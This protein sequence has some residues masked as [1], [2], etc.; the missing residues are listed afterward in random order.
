MSGYLD[1]ERT[2][3]AEVDAILEMIEAAGSGYHNTS[4]WRDKDNGPSYLERINE[5]IRE[6][7]VVLSEQSSVKVT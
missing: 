3:H 6:A 7:A 4:E 2:G 5:K 1:F